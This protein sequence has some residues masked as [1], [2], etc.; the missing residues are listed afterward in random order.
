MQEEILEQKQWKYYRVTFVISAIFIYKVTI[1]Y[2]KQMG[3]QKN[4]K[5]N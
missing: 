1:I 5:I 2:Y 4:D 3:E